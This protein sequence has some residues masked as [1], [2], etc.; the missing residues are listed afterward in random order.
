[1]FRKKFKLIFELSLIFF[2]YDNLKEVRQGKENHFLFHLIQ[3]AFTAIFKK[4]RRGYYF[5]W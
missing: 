4:M 5:V 3:F 1:M 2:I